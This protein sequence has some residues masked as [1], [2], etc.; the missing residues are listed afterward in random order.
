MI[1]YTVTKTNDGH[2]AFT[3]AATG[4]SFYRIV[5]WGV[6]LDA[7]TDVTWTWQQ[8]GSYEDF[9]PPLEI[10]YED[11]LTTSETYKPYMLLQWYAVPGVSYYR[12]DKY[13]GSWVQTDTII[14]NDSWLYSWQSPTLTDDTLCQYRVV[15]VDDQDDESVPRQY[16]RRIMCPPKPPDAD[17]AITYDVGTSSIVVS[18]A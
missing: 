16:T 11:T 9:P 6:Q 7:I 8:P 1:P 4:A 12:V 3:W 15:A 13:V 17:L 10:A 18:A 14:V 2:W 5:L